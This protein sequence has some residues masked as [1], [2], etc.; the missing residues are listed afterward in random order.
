MCKCWDCEGEMVIMLKELYVTGYK[1][2]ILDYLWPDPQLRLVYW[3][4]KLNCAFSVL[5]PSYVY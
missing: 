2:F 1:S 3:G 5:G 4:S